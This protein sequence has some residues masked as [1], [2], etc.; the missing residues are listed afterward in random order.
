MNHFVSSRAAPAP[1]PPKAARAARSFT[2]CRFPFTSIISARAAAA[3][4]LRE[5]LW[6]GAYSLA[7]PL[8]VSL[9]RSPHPPGGSGS[10]TPTPPQGALAA[11]FL[12]FLPGRQGLRPLPWGSL[13]C[14]NKHLGPASLEGQLYLEWHP[15]TPP[16]PL[17]PLSPPAPAA[18]PSHLSLFVALH[19]NL[20]CIG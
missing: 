10:P 18:P 20:R 14:S 16:S 8:L 13:Q 5:G 3:L 19:S 12:Q 4:E 1:Q 7:P 6:G 15:L 17:W 11:G 9:P 2:S